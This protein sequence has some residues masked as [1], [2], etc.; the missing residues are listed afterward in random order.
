VRISFYEHAIE[1]ST[2]INHHYAR[3]KQRYFETRGQWFTDSQRH[4]TYRMVEQAVLASLAEP[5]SSA[6]FD[7]Q[8]ADSI[9]HRGPRA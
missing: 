5:E 3:I 6:V 8:I 1:L 7:I 2:V 4:S 9:P